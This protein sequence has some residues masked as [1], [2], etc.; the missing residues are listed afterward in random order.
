M[1][2]HRTEEHPEDGLPGHWE[3]RY[4]PEKDRQ[5]MRC[6]TIDIWVPHCPYHREELLPCHICEAAG[7]GED[8]GWE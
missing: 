8:E 3:S 5:A 7:L 6:D 1:A 2:Y 4:V